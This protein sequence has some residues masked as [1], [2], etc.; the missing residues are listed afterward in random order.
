M[1]FKKALLLALLASGVGFTTLILILH[2]G[3]GFFQ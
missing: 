1:R 2:F 3:L